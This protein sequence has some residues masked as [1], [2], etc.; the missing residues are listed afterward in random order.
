MNYFIRVAIALVGGTGSIVAFH[1]AEDPTLPTI[2][3]I[4]VIVAFAATC[5]WRIL[6][7]E[8]GQN[9]RGD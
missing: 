7:P 1:E 4:V 3:V 9:A 2:M 5:V 8:K 6:H